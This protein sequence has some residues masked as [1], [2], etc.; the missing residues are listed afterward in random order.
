MLNCPILSIQAVTAGND[1]PIIV[2]I[3]GQDFVVSF[4][5]KAMAVQL[6]NK[7][8]GRV[9]SP[10]VDCGPHAPDFVEIYGFPVVTLKHAGW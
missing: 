10:G 3:R 2:A 1:Y 9:M 7:I 8:P 4:G 6:H 5:Q